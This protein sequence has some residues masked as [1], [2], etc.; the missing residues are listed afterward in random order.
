M[1]HK[2]VRIEEELYETVSTTAI[3]YSRSVAGQLAHWANIGRV[4]EK[5]PSFD[6]ER[7]EAA[8]KAEIP[9][10]DL[11]D[12]ENEIYMDR[13]Y[14]M[15]DETS[16]ASDEFYANLVAKGKELGFVEE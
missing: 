6:I 12:E 4:I 10:D 14:A 7:V 9:L 15:M 11:T 8:L 13:F 5:S 3:L 2:T 16:P 1:A